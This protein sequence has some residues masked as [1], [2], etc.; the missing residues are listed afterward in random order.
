[1][2][3]YKDVV[4]R[5]DPVLWENLLRHYVLAL[6]WVTAQC[7]LM[8]DGSFEEPKIPAW[9]TD[10]DLPTDA[11]RALY[12]DVCDDLFKRWAP[13][14][15]CTRL[16]SLT[17]PPR[18]DGLRFL[19][20]LIHAQAFVTITAFLVER[21]LIQPREIKVLPTPA[22]LDAVF[23]RFTDASVNPEVDLETFAFAA[24]RAREDQALRASFQLDGSG[25]SAGA[26]KATYLTITFPDHYVRGVVDHLVHPTWRT[27]CFTRTCTN[28]SNWA[29]YGDNHRGAALVFRPKSENG[30]IVLPVV[31]VNGI[32]HVQ[33]RPP[34]KIRS[35]VELELLPVNYVNRP[36]EVDF[37]QSLGTLP[38]QKIA[39][40]WHCDREGKPSPL[41]AAGL[42][43]QDAWRATYWSSFNQIATTK[44]EDWKHE[45]EYRIVMSDFSDLRSEKEDA[46]VEYDFSCLVGIV[47]G[48]RTTERDKLEIM[49]IIAAECGRARRNEFELYQVTYRA[50]RGCLVRL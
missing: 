47:F 34:Q 28:A 15:L 37:F 30:R 11:F 48:L 25:A 22:A 49:K 35:R 8:D 33:G 18:R 14:S 26:R 16:T 4:W 50:S 31:A 32:S 7:V 19:L 29:A 36:L 24:N 10:D 41:V 23:E 42:K 1:M 38:R 9:L 43:D 27:A 40:A 3:G 6:L 39:R 2:E 20:S 21:G 13:S 45:E 44:L 5:G 12:S 17:S 46:L